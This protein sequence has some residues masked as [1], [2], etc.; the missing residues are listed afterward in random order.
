[1]NTIRV[2]VLFL[3]FLIFFQFCAREQKTESKIVPVY[4]GSDKCQTC[5]VEAFRDF[6]KSNHYHALDTISPE[7]VKADFNNSSFVYFGDTALFYTRMGN[8]YVRTIDSTGTPKEF[9]ITYTIGWK[10]LQQYLVSFP[11]GRLQTLPFC[12]DTRSKAE[13]GQRWFHIYDKEKIPPRDELFWMGINQNWNNMCADCHTTEYFK[14][15]DINTNRF[16][17]TWKEDRVSCESCH[18]PGSGH[19]EWAKTKN[20]ADSSM[21]F[22][23]NLSGEKVSWN[24]NAERGISFPDKKVDNS[25][26]FETC[27]RC[28]ARATRLSDDYHYGRSL[29]NTHL[30]AIIDEEN[31]YVDGQIRNEDYE[32]GSFLQSKMFAAGVTC[33]NCHNPH[34]LKLKGEGNLVCASCHTP[35]KY[36][37]V[38]HTHHKPNSAGAQCVN[39]HMAVTTYMVVHNRRDHSIRI[40]R[41]DLS[42]S[43]GTPNACNKCHSE[44]TTKWALDNFTK[45]YGKRIP[46]EKTYGELLYSISRNAVGSETV[47]NEL[48]TGKYPDIIKATALHQNNRF[49]TP[50]SIEL[51]KANL[52][53]PDPVLRLN[54]INATSGMPAEMILQLLTPMI[55]DS[56]R[57]VRTEAMKDIAPFYAQ[58]VYG[59]KQRFGVVLLE[60]LEFERSMSDRPEGY[61][62]QGIIFHALGRAKEAEQIYLLGLSRHPDFVGFYVNIADLYRSN[63]LDSLAK[64]YLDKGLVLFPSTPGLHLSLALWYIRNK[65][66]DK[67]IKELELTVKLNPA[68]SYSTYALAIALQE[69]GHVKQGIDVLKNYISKYGNDPVILEALISL[70]Q[71]TGQSSQVGIYRNLRK[72]VLGY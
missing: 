18:G 66:I 69:T 39:C 4:S 33:V 56:I 41:P 62:N 38:E 50:R 51:I 30:P 72:E 37:V 35:S 25:L 23:I 58:L 54:S 1:M 48:L 57:V 27:S 16:Q 2:T 65:E 8:Y 22:V 63:D 19:I 3:F 32:H 46:V 43:L 49:Y 9:R 67:A 53:N 34:S 7:T 6:Q 52:Q 59:D 36:D 60:Y 47:W 31:Y 29:L 13:G 40:P 61:L 71:S 64:E 21:G 20:P 14:N 26:L 55:Y 44:K 12:W 10:P 17:S 5:H 28:H 42:E 15:Y 70:Y 68:D 45:W 24:L 11:D